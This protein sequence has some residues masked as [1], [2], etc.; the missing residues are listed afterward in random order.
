LTQ[1][2]FGVYVHIPFCL[3]RCH[4]CNFNTYEGVDDLHAPYVDALEREI[5]ELPG[6]LPA[7]TSVFFG[8]G[9]PTLLPP[10]AL[11]RLLIAI[12]SRTGLAPDAEITIEANP[13]TVDEGVFDAL[14]RAGANRFSIGIQSLDPGV[15]Q[16]LG[17]QHSVATAIAA[18]RAARTAGAGDLNIDL[19][20]GSPWETEA[21]WELTLDAALELEPDHISAYSLM[22]EPRTPLATLVATGREPDVD[23]DVQAARYDR[24]ESVLSAAGYARYETSNWA[25]PGRASRH[26][27]LY[28]S[29]GDHLG[30]GAGAHGHRAGR[31][32]WV[33]RL[34]RD[35]IGRIERGEPTEAGSETLEGESRADEALMLGLR[36]VS[37]I[38]RRGFRARFGIDPLEG[39]EQ[40]ASDLEGAGL[41]R[42]DAAGL[43]LAPGASFVANEVLARLL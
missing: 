42:V 15:L 34:P 20:F 9:T 5:C 32:S 37:G 28:W 19:I 11:A 26:N 36:L 29:A 4:Y 22:V 25:R 10:S 8:G 30:L 7:A 33:V 41:L 13:E 40:A 12:R 2:G 6:E 31:R 35:Y 14:L 17:R 39:R 3:H 38:D 24:A 43:A 1:P 18:V 27:L 21:A 16:R 23:P